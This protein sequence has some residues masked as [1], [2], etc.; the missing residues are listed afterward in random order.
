MIA[1]LDPRLWLALV[2]WTAAVAFLSYQQ[3]AGHERKE[4]ERRELKASNDALEEKARL[5]ADATARQRHL[6]RVLDNRH[7]KYFQ[8]ERDAKVKTDRL[9]ADLRA[10][11]RRLSIP[12]RNPAC[13]AGADPDAGTAAGTG[14]E[15][16]ADLTAGASEFLV[17]LADR[18]DAA[19]R[20]HAEVV[21]RYQLLQQFCEGRAPP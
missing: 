8:E 17:R 21:D 6:A 5:D 12:V 11:N 10:D 1:L 2:L 15:G 3:G 13:P 9:I 16:R 19:I 18:G 20:K 14:A 7:E 4:A